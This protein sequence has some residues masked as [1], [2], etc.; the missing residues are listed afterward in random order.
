MPYNARAMYEVYRRTR[1]AYN[2]MTLAASEEVNLG[3]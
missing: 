3:E 2:E 1:Q